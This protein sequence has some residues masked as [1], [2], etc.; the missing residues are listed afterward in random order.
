MNCTLPHHS[1]TNQPR[2]PFCSTAQIA[3][4]VAISN[5][6]WKWLAY[7]T[8]IPNPL[9]TG[10]CTQWTADQGVVTLAS[11][12]ITVVAP[13]QWSIYSK[14]GC[15]MGVAYCIVLY[16]IHKLHGHSGLTVPLACSLAVWSHGRSQSLDCHSHKVQYLLG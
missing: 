2:S 15:G 5:A 14:Y 11:V 10:R 8:N 12:I 9:P 3:S 16:T 4:V 1:L 13:E 6:E 7:E